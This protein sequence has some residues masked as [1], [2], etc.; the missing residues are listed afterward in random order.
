MKR[1]VTIRVRSRLTG[2]RMSIEKTC[3]FLA[4]VC[5]LLTASHLPF[6]DHIGE[7]SAR[8]VPGTRRAPRPSTP[9]MKIPFLPVYAIHLPLG[10]H[11]G[12]SPYCVTR[13]KVPPRAYVQTSYGVKNFFVAVNA[14]HDP[15]ATS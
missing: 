10:D 9:M 11:V 2:D 1:P 5:A 4:S 6:G 13:F 15:R 14:K 7:L 12:S 3:C 8:V